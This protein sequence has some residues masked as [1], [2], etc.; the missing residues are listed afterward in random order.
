[1]RNHKLWGNAWRIAAGTILAASLLGQ[2]ATAS[3]AVSP[4]T[5]VCHENRHD[6]AVSCVAEGNCAAMF[7]VCRMGC[8]DSIVPGPD[9]KECLVECRHERLSCRTEVGSCKKDCVDEFLSCRT[10]C[11]VH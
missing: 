5:G 10:E 4:C 9:R 3:A 7:N 6:C 2:A 11:N 1:M 8:I